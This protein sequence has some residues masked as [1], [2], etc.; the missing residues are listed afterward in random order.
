MDYSIANYR[1]PIASL[2]VNLPP[3]KSWF[4]V[5]T[6]TLIAIKMLASY[7]KYFSGYLRQCLN[8]NISETITGISECY[9]VAFYNYA[10]QNMKNAN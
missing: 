5:Y 4:K 8:M 1:G 9:E 3:K 6:C 10:K 7:I 2:T